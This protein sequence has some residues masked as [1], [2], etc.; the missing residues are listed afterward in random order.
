MRREIK[1]HQKYKVLQI[2][3]DN[4]M[5]AFEGN[6]QA[7]AIL[8]SF[9]EKNNQLAEL[10]PKVTRPVSTLY[11]P[12]MNNQA[13]FVKML[14][15][16]IGMA[17]A[18]AAHTGNENQLHTWKLYRKQ[19]YKASAYLLYSMATHLSE[20]LAAQTEILHGLGFTV[21]KLETFNQMISD[22]SI[23]VDETRH[24][25]NLRSTDWVS[26]NSCLKECNNLVTN[27]I[28]PLIK[29]KELDFPGLYNEW[30]NQRKTKKSKKSDSSLPKA[31]FDISGTVTDTVTSRPVP[32]AIVSLTQQG[33]VTETDE[34]GYYIFDELMPGAYTL[35][36]YAPGYNVSDTVPVTL[37]GES[38]VVDFKLSPNQLLN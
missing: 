20:E 35:N 1:R 18:V 36:C 24:L 26:V 30:Q 13:A 7:L 4:H 21:E 29:S 5:Q 6:Q 22:F 32:Y 23:L 34:D 28:D 2:T 19:S 9:N 10:L 33:T 15:N 16:V 14:R 25:L 11:R 3:L 12:K 17:I 27:Q 38:L 31:D 8:N 37:D